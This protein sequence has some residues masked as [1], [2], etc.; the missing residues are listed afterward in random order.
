MFHRITL[1]GRVGQAP[2]MRYTPDGTPV[3]SFSV[4][5]TT[6]LAKTRPD[7]QPRPC[8]NGW[9]ESIS[10]RTWE[11]VTWWRITCWRGLAETVNAYLTKGEAVFV[12][13]TMDGE[14]ANSTQ[15]PRVWTAADGSARASFE[16]TAQTVRF[17]TDRQ[18]ETATAADDDL[19]F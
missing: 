7:G 11:L 2:Q 14:S 9:K 5:T 10:G 6:R 18:Q 16:L 8:P 1:I 13:G 3:S 4:A 19:P 12:E 15:Y 17:F